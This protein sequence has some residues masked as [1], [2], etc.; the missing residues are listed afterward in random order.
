MY[1]VAAAAAS[2]SSQHPVHHNKVIHRLARIGG[3]GTRQLPSC[4]LKCGR[5]TIFATINYIMLWNA[6]REFVLRPSLIHDTVASC[7]NDNCPLAASRGG[8][9]AGHLPQDAFCL[10]ISGLG[11]IL[12]ETN[13]RRKYSVRD[14]LM[15][16]WRWRW[17]GSTCWLCLL[18]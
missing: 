8:R 1:V 9:G 2:H 5:I 14:T 7:V 16:P 15:S 4:T 17:R 10:C 6:K 3:T 18:L 11:E 13:I 12:R